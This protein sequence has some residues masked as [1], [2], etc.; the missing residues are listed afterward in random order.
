VSV[1]LFASLLYV[2]WKRYTFK[3]KGEDGHFEP[4]AVHYAQ[5]STNAKR[6]A[7]SCLRQNMTLQVAAADGY[8]MDKDIFFEDIVR[9]IWFEMSRGEDECSS[10]ITGR[11][12]EM[13][14]RLL[15]YDLKEATFGNRIHLRTLKVTGSMESWMPLARVK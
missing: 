8:V 5:A 9:D 11:G 1:L 15:G 10:E 14:N 13:A 4:A 2:K 7:V 6:A 12:H 3:R